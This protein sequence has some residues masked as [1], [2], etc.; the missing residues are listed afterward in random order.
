MAS[1][2][3]LELSYYIKNTHETLRQESKIFGP[4]L[5]W[6]KHCEKQDNLRKYA[7]AMKELAT[8]H[9]QENYNNNNSKAISRI[10]WIFRIC[11][12]YFEDE[13]LLKY[14]RKE[15]EIGFKINKNFE[16][17]DLYV[18]SNKVNLLDVGSCY[19][20]FSKFDFFNVIPID[21]AP[22][23][24][25]VYECDFLNVLLADM[26]KFQNNK[27]IKIKKNYFQVIVFSLLLEY[28]PSAK[29]RLS[30]C[31]K[32]Y[33]LLQ[34]EGLLI[35]ITPDSKHVGANA[36]FMKSWRFLLARLGF[37]R[38][39]YEKLPHIHCM[40]FRKSLDVSIAARWSSIYSDGDYY[41]EMYIPQDFNYV[42][43]KDENVD[44]AYDSNYKL[45]L[46]KE[47]P[48]LDSV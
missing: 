13:E 42:E 12:L 10:E 47:L 39:K 23:N 3:H 46:M 32:A 1:D 11:I 29:Q 35:I 45:E 22:A 36:K 48:G 28:L 15:E 31:Q 34:T 43:E 40:V 4:E 19:N 44:V 7:L 24:E 5:A 16:C 17:I 38:I 30:C 27:L 26:F 9:W 33:D 37:S 14:R 8:K 6:K 21:I 18:S 20:P 41:E 2:D 25:D